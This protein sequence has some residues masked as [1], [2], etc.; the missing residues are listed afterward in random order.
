MQLFNEAEAGRGLG[1]GAAIQQ[2]SKAIDLRPLFGKKYAPFYGAIYDPADIDEWYMARALAW[3]RTKQYHGAIEDYNLVIY[4]APNNPEAHY[5][6]GLAYH[7]AGHHPNARPA[8]DKACQLD[9]SRVSEWGHQNF[10]EFGLYFNQF[11]H[12]NG[13]RY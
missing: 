1:Y 6:R 8:F 13:S 2:F 11:C 7:M 10:P 5:N 9:R 4:W 12:S 3:M